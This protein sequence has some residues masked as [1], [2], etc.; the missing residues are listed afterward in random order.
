MVT[1]LY[2]LTYDYVRMPGK[3]VL[4][5]INQVCD[6]SKKNDIMR[7]NNIFKQILLCIAFLSSMACSSLGHKDADDNSNI[8]TAFIWRPFVASAKF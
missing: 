6:P 4:H 3:V 8:D 5:I 2:E 1:P 7:M